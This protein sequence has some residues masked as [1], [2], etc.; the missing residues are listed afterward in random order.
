VPTPSD[1]PSTRKSASRTKTRPTA[2]LDPSTQRTPNEEASPETLV[3]DV[4]RIDLTREQV[5][6][7]V[8]RGRWIA[9]RAYDLAQARGF[10]PGA[11]LDDWLQAEREYDEGRSRQAA[12]QPTTGQMR[13]ED[14][15]TG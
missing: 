10:A 6:S 9:E 1:K 5:S 13:P 8:D 11:E 12:D 2:P 14:Q 7:D 15:F 4:V 3:P